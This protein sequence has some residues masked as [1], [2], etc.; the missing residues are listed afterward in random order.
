MD[1]LG[2][3]RVDPFGRTEV[4]Q[5]ARTELPS[6]PIGVDQLGRTTVDLIPRSMTFDSPHRP[7]SY[8][9]VLPCGDEKVDKPVDDFLS[10]LPRFP[11]SLEHPGT[12]DEPHPTP[13]LT[14][15]FVGQLDPA[16]MRQVVVD[17]G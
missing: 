2:R 7:F 1:P 5:L 11:L 13:L 14:L 9:K 15:L 17:L 12:A 3:T 16:F 6:R 8:S 4:D 10:A